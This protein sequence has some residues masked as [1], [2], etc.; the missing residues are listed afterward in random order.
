MAVR[1]FTQTQVV[2][3]GDRQQQPGIGRQAVIVE[4]NVDAV[5]VVVW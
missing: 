2:G 5:W 3:Q 1:Q 4:G